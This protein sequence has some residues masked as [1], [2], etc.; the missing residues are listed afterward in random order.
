MILPGSLEGLVSVLCCHQHTSPVVGNPLH[1][2]WNVEGQLFKLVSD[3]PNSSFL[4]PKLVIPT[5][6]LN[7]FQEKVL[8]LTHKLPQ[9]RVEGTGFLQLV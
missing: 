9:F 2:R 7:L 1:A 6:S 3:G 8:Y 5:I 4:H